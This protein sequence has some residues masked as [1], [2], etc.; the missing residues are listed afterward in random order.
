MLN[1]HKKTLHVGYTDGAL[2]DFETARHYGEE[3][4]GDYCFAEPYPHIVID[5]FLPQEV[6][7]DLL[8]HF[9]ERHAGTGNGFKNELFEHNKRAISPYDCDQVSRHLFL[10]FNSAPFLKFLEAMTMIQALIPDPFFHGGG[11]HEISRGGKLGIHADFRINMDL[12]LRRR[13][14][15]LVYLNKGWRPEFGGELELW[16]RK[17]T[18][19]VHAIEPLFNRCVIFNTDADSYHGH[20]EPL[21]TPPGMTR[22]SLALYYYTASEAI[23]SETPNVGTNFKARPQDSEAHK[24]AETQVNRKNLFAARELLPPLLYRTLRDFRRRLR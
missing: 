18:R 8:R 3:L 19:K 9:P 7:D 16:D 21:D 17:M 11:F 14:N 13:L 24:R 1:P 12:H 15:V 4:C 20:P 6:A 22:R 23:Y 2:L 5:E 10:F